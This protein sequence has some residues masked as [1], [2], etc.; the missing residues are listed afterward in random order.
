MIGRIVAELEGF[1]NIEHNHA[2]IPSVRLFAIG[3][4]EYLDL[5]SRNTGDQVSSMH[6]T[7]L[8][9]RRSFEIFEDKIDSRFKAIAEED[10]EA[11]VMEV[12][13]D[14]KARLNRFYWII[15]SPSATEGISLNQ[16]CGRVNTMKQGRP[17]NELTSDPS[18]NDSI[19]SVLDHFSCRVLLTLSSRPEETNDNE[20]MLKFMTCGGLF[21]N[22]GTA[23]SYSGSYPNESEGVAHFRTEDY[24]DRFKT[25]GKRDRDNH[26][27]TEVATEERKPSFEKKMHKLIDTYKS[28]VVKEN[29]NVDTQS[30]MD[31]YPTEKLRIGMKSPTLEMARTRRRLESTEHLDGRKKSQEILGVNLAG[32]I[33]PPIQ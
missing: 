29:Y 23:P 11:I 33:D 28:V 4:R 7:H 12:T 19:V 15:C 31:T 18:G 21:S 27:D 14:R 1:K 20:Q 17:L 26:Q 3:K 13:V 24:E 8:I 2:I 10:V 9:N 32:I 16:M 6:S 30:E 22:Q 5:M 25:A